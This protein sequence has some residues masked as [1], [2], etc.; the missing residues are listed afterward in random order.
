MLDFGLTLANLLICDYM[1]AHILHIDHIYHSITY[2]IESF[3]IDKQIA[4]F[5][6]SYSTF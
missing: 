2:H 3:I 1:Y 4:Y 5:Y 6:L